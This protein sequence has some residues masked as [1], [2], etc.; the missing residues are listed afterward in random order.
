MT[1]TSG[2]LYGRNVAARGRSGEGAMGTGQ[3]AQ[4]VS[5]TPIDNK[6]VM[7]GEQR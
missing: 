5:I 7:E 6:I 3:T 2:T 4:L 1:G